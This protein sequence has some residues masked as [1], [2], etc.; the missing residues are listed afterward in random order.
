[1]AKLV[2]NKGADKVV[3]KSTHTLPTRTK[4]I[5]YPI[6]TCTQVIERSKNLRA[7]LAYPPGQNV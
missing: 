5:S 6:P 4:V 3:P 2:Q 1:M 7:T